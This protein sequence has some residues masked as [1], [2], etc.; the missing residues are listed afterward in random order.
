MMGYNAETKIKVDADV[1][2]NVIKFQNVSK[3]FPKE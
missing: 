2:N 1:T 3:Q